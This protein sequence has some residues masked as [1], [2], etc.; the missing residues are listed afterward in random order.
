MTTSLLFLGTGD[1]FCNGGRLH[2]A[3]HL[4]CGGYNALLD[5]GATTIAVMRHLRLDVAALDAVLVTHLH[6]DHFGG[7]PF[8]LLDACYNARRT[9]PLVIAGPAGTRLRLMDTLGCLYPGAPAKVDEMLSLQFVEF[10]DR[11]P[12]RVGPLGVLPVPVSH[13]SGAASF[14]LRVE[15]G[16]RLVAFSGDSAWT[17]AIA[18]I[19]RGADL[20]I[21][22]CYAYDTEVPFHVRWT[23]LRPALGELDARRVVLTHL[24]PDMLAHL[25][26][27]DVEVAEDGQVIDL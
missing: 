26:E 21:C 13:P 2:T 16:G 17:P 24:G 5:C 8:L 6:G 23:Q 4:R 9:K 12:V 20:F 25:G 10:R 14:G 22:E 3:F 27:L 18:E 19:A 7:I 11:E 15:S 1:A